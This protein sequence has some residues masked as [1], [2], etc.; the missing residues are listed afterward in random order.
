M[1]IGIDNFFVQNG[2]NYSLDFKFES[3]FNVSKMS[4]NGEEINF[5]SDKII[6]DDEGE[7][8]NSPKNPMLP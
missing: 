4:V 1:F 8:K 2:D 7:K 5:N 3:D 6:F